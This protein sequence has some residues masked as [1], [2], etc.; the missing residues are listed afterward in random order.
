MTSFPWSKTPLK[1]LLVIILAGAINFGLILGIQMLMNYRTE[2]PI[3][4]AALERLDEQWQG[5]EILDHR[6][7]GTR[8]NLHFYL[9]R[10]IDGSLHFL[11]LRRHYLMERYKVMNKATMAVPEE[12]EPF[13]LKAGTCQLEVSVEVNNQTGE[14]YLQIDSTF[15]GQH[16][17][18][19]FKNQMILSIAGLCILE[20]AVWCLLFRKEE[21]A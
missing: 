3:D 10:K 4:E 15:M 11:T 14:P 19:Q 21:I 18:Q 16:A 2:G 6:E 1:M 12:G 7:D 20:L 17:G 8:Q 5:C 9:V 13:R